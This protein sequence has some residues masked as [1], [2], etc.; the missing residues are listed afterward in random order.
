MVVLLALAGALEANHRLADVY[1]LHQA[2]PLQLVEDPVDARAAHT[3]AV[4]GAERVLDLDRGQR[5]P[6]RAK[7]LEHRPARAAALAAGRRERHLRALDPA[8]LAHAISLEA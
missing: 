2:Q 7:Q 8:R 5:A 3:P 1:A 6:L 4:A